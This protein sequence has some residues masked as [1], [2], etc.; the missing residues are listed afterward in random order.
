MDTKTHNFDTWGNKNFY[1]KIKQYKIGKDNQGFFID[2]NVFDD[3]MSTIIDIT[4][5]ESCDILHILN[6]YIK[7]K[8]FL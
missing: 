5:F 8:S 4:E 1:L 3:D 7:L 6:Q 2:M